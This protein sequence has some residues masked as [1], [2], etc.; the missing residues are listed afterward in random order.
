[1]SWLLVA[2]VLKGKINRFVSKFFW[3]PFGRLTTS[4]NKETTATILTSFDGDPVGA[5]VGDVLGDLEGL[6]VGRGETVGLVGAGV[7]E[8]QA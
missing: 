4:F 6:D 8:K 2:D 1:M 7:G 5:W 3:I